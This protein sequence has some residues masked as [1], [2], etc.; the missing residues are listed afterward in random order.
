MDTAKLPKFEW[1][2]VDEQNSGH[3]KDEWGKI[4]ENTNKARVIEAYTIV[5]KTPENL[6]DN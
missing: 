1:G 3:T 6:Q 5:W 4:Q 2:R